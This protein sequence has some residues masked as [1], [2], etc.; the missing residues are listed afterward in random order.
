MGNMGASPR[1]HEALQITVLQ[2]HS[3]D[4][5]PTLSPIPSLSIGLSTTRLSRGHKMAAVAP[6]ITSHFRQGERL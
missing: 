2:N 4:Q 3:G 6:A 1:L 5:V